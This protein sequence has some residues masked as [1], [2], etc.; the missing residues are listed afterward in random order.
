MYASSERAFAKHHISD[1]ATDDHD[2]VMY[3]EAEIVS[4]LTSMVD[5]CLA[6]MERPAVPGFCS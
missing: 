6:E 4:L 2:I 3:V 5:L 1:L